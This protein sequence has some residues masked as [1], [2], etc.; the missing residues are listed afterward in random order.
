MCYSLTGYRLY[1]YAISDHEMVYVDLDVNARYQRPIQRK[2]WL[3]SKAD[4][5]VL[6]QPML[7]FSEDFTDKHSIKS[8]VNTMWTE[9]SDICATFPPSS[10]QSGLTG[11]GQTET[12]RG[13]PAEREKKL[14]RRLGQPRKSLIGSI[15]KS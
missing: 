4:T 12:S 7:Q 14:A 8:D 6:K 15:I 1:R 3:W 2:I 13:C 10:Y 5:P 11:H 9:F